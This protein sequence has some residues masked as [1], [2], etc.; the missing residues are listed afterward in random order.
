M[1]RREF[2]KL[3]GS[4][5]S[6]AALAEA[7]VSAQQAQAPAKSGTVAPTTSARAKMKVGTQHG[8]QP[9]TSCA[10]APPSASTTSA[11][12]CRSAKMDDAWSVE[13]L[14]RL[15]DRVAAHDISLDMVPLPMSSSEISS[16]EMPA[17]YLGQ[18]PERDRNI[19][20]ICQMI[21]N[22]AARRHH[23]GEIQLHDHRHSAQRTAKDAAGPGTASSCSPARR[24]IRR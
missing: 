6:T 10:P 24:R 2:V 12:G 19:D 16:A 5:M 22:C 8:R 11:A 18:S 3:A 20:D 7:V 17:I 4:G 15:R 9:K 14:S 13:G 21:R 23:A 1:N